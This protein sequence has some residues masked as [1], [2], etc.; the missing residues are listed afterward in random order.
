VAERAAANRLK[1]LL[2][3]L[4]E[5]SVEVNTKRLIVKKTLLDYRNAAGSLAL[6]GAITVHGLHLNANSRNSHQM[7]RPEAVDFNFT[8]VK[9]NASN[10]AYHIRV[11]G[12]RMQSRSATLSLTNVFIIPRYGKYEFSR[13]LGY[14]A[15]RIEGGIDRV[16][17]THP[18]W[19]H[20]A[21][22]GVYA[23]SVK[24]E[25]YNIH[26]F[27]DRR[28]PLRPDVQPLPMDCLKKMAFTVKIKELKMANG[29]VS[30]EEF[31]KN[32]TQTG[33]LRIERFALA[34]APFTN[35]AALVNNRCLVLTTAGAIMGS[36]N[37]YATMFMPFDNDK[38][39]IKGAINNLDLTM[40]N[41]SSENLGKI[42]IKSGLLDSLGF[43]FG[44]DHVKSSGKIVGIY[45]RLIIQ[46]LKRKG[47]EQGEKKIAKFQSFM[48]RHLV[49]P[50]NKGRSMPQSN[51]TGTIA[52]NRDSTRMVSY[53]LLQSLLTG[54]K[55]SFKLGF[56]LPK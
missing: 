23:A 7:F 24:I 10:S 20:L 5:S 54:I 18:D 26:V 6:K 13:R 3:L 42:R 29:E 17:I 16:I 15:D 22:K 34:I 40:L 4:R 50:L 35:R 1:S 41:S 19:N 14:Q 25:G 43:E 31:P 9:F 12:A 46:P 37:V 49:I 32:G 44:F 36:G 53:Y 8:D 33:I 27:R 11:G 51:R 45:H 39:F 2:R 52:Y 55:S 28:L 47:F 56:L 21:N 30:Y 38:Y 48:L